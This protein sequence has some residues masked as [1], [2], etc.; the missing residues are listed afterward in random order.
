MSLDNIT[1][2]EWDKQRSAFSKQ[3]GGSHYKDSA[4]QPIEFILA[5]DLGFCEGNVIKYIMRHANKG[6][7][8]DLQK[9][10]HYTEMLMEQKYG[11]D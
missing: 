5:N 2:Q 1:P 11:K 10:I 7:K 8:Q 9:V 3:V 4:I 6:G